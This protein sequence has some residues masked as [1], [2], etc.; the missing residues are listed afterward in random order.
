MNA[1]DWVQIGLGV[2]A[3]AGTGAA[4]W[5]ASQ[6][7]RAAARQARLLFEL[8]T[9]TR[10]VEVL[11]VEPWPSPRFHT[12]ED[13][14]RDAQITSL[15]GALGESR[16]PRLWHQR[17][18]NRPTP[19]GSTWKVSIDDIFTRKGA[20]REEALDA[21]DAIAADLRAAEGRRLGRKRKRRLGGR[22]RAPAGPDRNNS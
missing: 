5:I 9:V 2:A 8:D 21:L 1:G 12:P 6:D 4:L 11:A 16:L 19:P 22:F 13:D 18:G 17:F 15:V 3:L 10:L 14:A 20:S 7:R